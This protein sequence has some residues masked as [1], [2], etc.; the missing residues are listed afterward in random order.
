M[1]ITRAWVPNNSRQNISAHQQ[2]LICAVSGLAL[3][4][5]TVSPR[6]AL[7]TYQTTVIDVFSSVSF[8]VC[9]CVWY[10]RVNHT[11]DDQLINSKRACTHSILFLC[12]ILYRVFVLILIIYIFLLQTI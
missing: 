10:K 8:R 9:V 1:L 6:H 2:H 3:Q 5:Q 7:M 11:Y 12:L 4:A